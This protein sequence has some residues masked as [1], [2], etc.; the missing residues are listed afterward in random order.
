[1]EAVGAL[2]PELVKNAAAP[3]KKRAGRWLLAAASIAAA[4]ALALGLAAVIR[5]ARKAPE[6]AVKDAAA[7]TASPTKAPEYEA[8]SYVSYFKYNGAIYLFNENYYGADGIL[9]ERI[10]NIANNVK[11][12]TPFDEAPELSGSKLCDIYAVK[13]FDPEIMICTPEGDFAAVYVNTDKSRFRTGEDIL[14]GAFHA[15]EY[16]TSLVYEGPDSL[17]H[18]YA[19]RFVLDKDCLPAA[20]ELIS[21]LDAG[22]WSGPNDGEAPVF[23]HYGGPE[24][25]AL[26]LIL[27]FYELRLTVFADGRATVHPLGGGWGE[28]YIL[29]EAEKAEPFFKLLRSGEHGA[30]AEPSDSLVFLRPEAVCAEPHFGAYV[31]ETP[32][33]YAIEYAILQYK[34]DETTFRPIP[35]RVK[36]L[37][38]EYRM[39]DDPNRS[40]RITVRSAEALSEELMGVDGEK[41]CD[42]P[43]SALDESTVKN[44]SPGFY[45]VTGCDETAAVTI[46]AYNSLTPAEMAAL[47]HE[48]FGK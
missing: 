11:P 29:F 17:D 35:D 18:G 48:C 6:N 45:D 41:R 30:P 12:G 39:K 25:Y 43:I 8:E 4:A 16:L 9:G 23:G 27:G 34:T 15:S 46:N 13:G 19:E 20:L 3:E 21:A 42:A 24:R 47:M 5:G 38:V 1:M 2:D 44:S 32:E 28:Y 10:A 40:F 37:T 36:S 22:E 7:P 26:T 33:G 31:P 14:E